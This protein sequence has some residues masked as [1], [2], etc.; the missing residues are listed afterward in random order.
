MLLENESTVRPF[1]EKKYQKIGID[2]PQKVAFWTAPSLIFYVKQAREYYRAAQKSDLFVR[3]LLVYYG[4]MTL[5]KALMLTLDPEYP[6]N[7]SLLRHGVSTRKRKREHFRFFTD[8]VKA[9][10]EGLFSALAQTYGWNEI[11][12]E[13]WIMQEMFALIPEIQ[14]GYRQL[15]SKETLYPIALPDLS[16]DANEGMPFIVEERILDVLHLTPQAMVN[17]LNNFPETE[18]QF[19]YGEKPFLKN[20]LL[21]YW[22]HPSVQHVDQWSLGFH[23]PMFREDLSGGYFLCPNVRDHTRCLPERFVHYI[24]LFALSM[25][26]RYEPPLWGEI[27]YGMISEERVL[28]EEFLQVTQR[29]FPNLILNELF[30]EKILFQQI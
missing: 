2:Q 20:R 8:E 1:L 22:H 14:D 15:F 24:L 6:K 26:C 5:S 23:H 18:V 27:I 9:Q 17:R 16:A 25:L 10:R 28:I 3:P 29:K 12:G 19:S 13:K 11:I 30:E 4:M 21:L 7:S